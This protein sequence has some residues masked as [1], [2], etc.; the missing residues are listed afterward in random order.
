M[1]KESLLTTKLIAPCGMNCSICYAYLRKKNKC[2]GCNI[3]DKNKPITRIRCKIKTCKFFK[4]KKAKFCFECN[5][6]PCKNL[7]HL[8]KRY[9][10]KYHMSQIENL[11]NIETKG[12]NNFIKNQEIKYTCKKCSGTI[13][14]HTNICSDCK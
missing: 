6:F 13:C 5:D 3:P 11:K 9:K 1:K 2:P 14:V 4:N 8:D 12:I 7:L 10:T